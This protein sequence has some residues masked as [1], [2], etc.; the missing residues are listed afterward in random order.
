MTDALPNIYNVEEDTFTKKVIDASHQRPILV[1]F[2]ADWCSPCLVLAPALEGVINEENGRIG[3]AKVEVDDN[4][5]LAGH[6]RLRG[7]PTVLGFVNGKEIAR[8]ASAKPKH[9]I[10]EFIQTHFPAE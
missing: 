7:F 5:R 6:Y 9:W 2:W 4:M 3:L 10:R 8:F 1:D